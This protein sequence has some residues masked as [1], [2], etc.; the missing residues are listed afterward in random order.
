MCFLFLWHT[1]QPVIPP[2]PL[3]HWFEFGSVLLER[4]SHWKSVYYIFAAGEYVTYGVL[5][6]IP[7]GRLTD[8]AVV[9]DLG[10]WF[11]DSV[12][13]TEIVTDSVWLSSSCGSW[14]AV[15]GLARLGPS[16]AQPVQII[17]PLCNVTNANE[18]PNGAQV[19][20]QFDIHTVSVCITTLF[21]L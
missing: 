18:Q 6:Y 17:L 16:P 4:F 19:P 21:C 20:K 8:A 5:V 2:P 12:V 7:P 11:M 10:S 13:V 9:I 3:P 1:L 14:D 15:R